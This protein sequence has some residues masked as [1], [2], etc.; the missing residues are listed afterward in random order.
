MCIVLLC[1]DRNQV[2]ASKQ[3]KRRASTDLFVSSWFLEHTRLQ[4]DLEKVEQVWKIMLLL[5]SC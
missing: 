1:P 3:N 2:L 5:N 4:V